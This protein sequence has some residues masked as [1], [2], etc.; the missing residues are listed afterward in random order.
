MGKARPKHSRGG[1]ECFAPWRDALRRIYS[2]GSDNGHDKAW[3]PRDGC[4]LLLPFVSFR[5]RPRCRVPV[6]HVP[7]DNSAHVA[8]FKSHLPTSPKHPKVYLSSR[9][10]DL[11]AERC[12]LPKTLPFAIFPVSHVARDN[13]V[14]ASEP[15]NATC[16]L[17]GHVMRLGE[18]TP[19]P[20]GP[21]LAH[22]S[23]LCALCERTPLLYDSAGGPNVPAESDGN[24][25]S[26]SRSYLVLSQ[27]PER[28][29]VSASVSVLPRLDI[30]LDA[31]EITSLSRFARRAS[32]P[33]AK[34]GM[35]LGGKP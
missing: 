2:I 6:S 5:V 3:P 11:I 9:F 21:E 33:H 27:I 18:R 32:K 28:R 1:Y 26:F 13:R 25:V 17:R 10:R 34:E 23:P 7:R 4:L 31:V 8:W 14:T 15:R 20:N 30:T 22:Y 24:Y 19:H 35:Y 29:A 12:S 16:T